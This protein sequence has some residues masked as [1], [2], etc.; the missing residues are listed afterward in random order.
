MKTNKNNMT[1][2]KEVAPDI[3]M[4][5]LPMNSR[6]SKS[7]VNAFVLAGNDG[8]VFDSG[9]GSWRKRTPLVDTICKITR[10]KKHRGQ[11]CD[12]KR[13]IASHGHWDH[14][15]G[16]GH[17]QDVLGIEV[18]ATEK[19]VQKIGSKKNFKAS[20]HEKNEHLNTPE[21]LVRWRNLR[22]NLI[23]EIYMGVAKVCFVSGPITVISENTLLSINGE[24]WQVIPVPG[25][26]DDD[27][28]LF[29]SQRGIMLG[30]DLILLS[31]NTWLGPPKSDL[32]TYLNSLERLLKL[33]GLKVILAAHGSPITEPYQRI[34]AIIKHR[35][36]KADD[37][38]HLVAG[39]GKQG[40]SYPEIFKIIYPKT[41]YFQRALLGGMVVV[42][43]D[44]LIGQKKI[45]TSQK[46][47]KTIYKV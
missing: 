29:N 6:L 25:H 7:S 1:S 14:F 27:I 40:L 36:K 12:I 37:L 17:L 23:T 33:P 3:F 21:S 19:Q 44:Y 35:K 38:F 26:S 30:G 46:N 2:V 42:T 20:F 41:N 28:V 5:S 34:E 43:L 47:G 11:A 8:L 31:I 10:Q 9:Y 24:S 4:V 16:L 13:A 32:K 39:S 18:L 45:I 22:D 15:S